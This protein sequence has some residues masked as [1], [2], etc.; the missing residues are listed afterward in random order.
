MKQQ[1]GGIPVNT[2][3]PTQEPT[4]WADNHVAIRSIMGI[5]HDNEKPV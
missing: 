4:S 1:N 3:F 2:C 5:G